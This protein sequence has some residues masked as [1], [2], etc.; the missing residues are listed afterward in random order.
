MAF[1]LGILGIVAGLLLILVVLLQNSKGGGLDTSNSMVNQI[2]NVAQSTDTVEKITW[3]LAAFI[4]VL[5]LAAVFIGKP[6]VS[7]PGVE[8]DSIN[9]SATTTVPTSTTLPQ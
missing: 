5:C 4:G 1:I 3:Y 2:G 9:G 8:A 6:S 7:G